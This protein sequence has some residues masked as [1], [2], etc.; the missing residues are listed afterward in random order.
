MTIAHGSIFISANKSLP[1]I[2]YKEDLLLNCKK[3]SGDF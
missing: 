2:L 1:D 3:V